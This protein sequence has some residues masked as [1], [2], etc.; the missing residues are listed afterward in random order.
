MQKYILPLAAGCLACAGI[1]SADRG[2]SAAQ[3]SAQLS[4]AFGGQRAMTAPLHFSM[5]LD[6]SR[7]AGDGW[8]PPL[9]RF[10][11]NSVNGGLARLGGLPLIRTSVRLGQFEDDG[12]DAGAE[13]AER[14]W[15]D[16]VDFEFSE[17]TWKD[18]TMLGGSVVVVGL[19][20]NE[21]LD[22]D[23]SSSPPDEGGNGDGG[24]GG[25]PLPD[26]CEELPVCPLPVAGASRSPGAN[27]ATDPA[28][29]EWLNGGTGQMGDLR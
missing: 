28:Y 21:L 17:Y 15:F 20:A 14:G 25:L 5:Q 19:A 4:Y 12:F 6:A 8:Q 13:G 9:L 16:F 22:S 7:N 18:W 24:G 11:F 23:S 29:L 1:A 3:F 27:A 2:D 26:P 10:D